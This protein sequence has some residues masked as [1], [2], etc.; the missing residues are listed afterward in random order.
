MAL[1]LDQ[2]DALVQPGKQGHLYKGAAQRS[3]QAHNVRADPQEGCR[4]DLAL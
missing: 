4:S 1:K 2:L 3:G